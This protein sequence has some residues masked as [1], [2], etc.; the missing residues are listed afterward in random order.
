[1]AYRKRGLSSDAL[2]TLQQSLTTTIEYYEHDLAISRKLGDQRAEIITLCQLGHASR[3]LGRLDEAGRYYER[4]LAVSGELDDRVG[5]ALALH[6]LGDLRQDDM[7]RTKA[8]EMSHLVV[9]I[10]D[11]VSDLL[12][13][14]T[15]SESSPPVEHEVEITPQCCGP[16]P[17]Q[18]PSINP[19]RH[20]GK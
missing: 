5:E 16:K 8:H 15:P 14:E 11:K 4:A 7:L 1:M 9:D 17:R 10:L 20:L 12:G 2:S 19:E 3:D 6:S 18:L 13:E